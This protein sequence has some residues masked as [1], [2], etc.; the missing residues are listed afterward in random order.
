MALSAS[1]VLKAALAWSA[2]SCVFGLD[3]TPMQKVVQLLGDLKE[4]VLAEGAEELAAYTNFSKFCKNIKAEKATAI[5][6]GEDSM[7]SLESSID[8][9]KAKY[10]GKLAK[11]QGLKVKIESLSAQQDSKKKECKKGKFTF[12]ANDADLTAAVSA[13]AAAMKKVKGGDAS[14]LQLGSTLRLA[15]A[16][17]LKLG[18]AKPWLEDEGA[19]YNKSK[20]AFQSSGIVATL[21]SLHT[22]FT[23]EKEDT[24]REWKWTEGNCTAADTNFTT[25]TD[26]KTDELS[27][28]KQDASSLKEELASDKESLLSTTKTLREDSAYQAELAENCNARDKD[29][30]QRSAQRDD[31]LGAL[32]QAND[33]LVKE[34]EAIDK[35]V[36]GATSAANSKSQSLLSAPA[37]SFLQHGRGSQ[38]GRTA[39]KSSRSALRAKVADQLAKAASRLGSARLL[40]LSKRIAAAEPNDP[41]ATVKDMVNGMIQGLLT[42]AANESAEKGFCDTEMEKATNDRQKFFSKVSRTNAKLYSLDAKR[43]SFVEETE[44][45][46][47]TVSK[48]TEEHATATS[49]RANE[50]A[51]NLKTIK[52]SKAAVKAVEKAMDVIKDFYK[53]AKNSWSFVQQAQKPPAAPKGEYKG[54]QAGSL[55]IVAM[56]EVCRDDFA[57][58]ADTTQADEK[59]DDED[60]AKLDEDTK[61]DI[62]GKTTTKQLAEEDLASAVS[63]LKQGKLEMKGYMDNLDES[64][65]RLQELKPRCVDPK[66]SFEENQ[67][68]RTEQINALKAAMCSLDPNNVEEGC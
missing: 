22:Q 21:E 19:E 43:V 54:K 18:K 16:L 26:K 66:Q 60:F 40:G 46:G 9:N 1:G 56:M 63:G 41:L 33:I 39:A 51:A 35:T 17:G 68:K 6:N 11:I 59:E 48:L 44:V 8:A 55:G 28:A 25:L 61:A 27:T 23:Q 47:D 24:T 52:D 50:S 34:V 12:E 31:E 29:W 20:Y 2:M 7:K 42:E 3:V 14:F 30:K 67:A 32:G 57:R 10:E 65:E 38:Q 36:N 62:A 58:T 13:L 53:K 4:G 37:T 45:L 5:Q 64:L 15:N 49:L